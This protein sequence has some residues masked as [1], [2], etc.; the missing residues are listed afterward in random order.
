MSSDMR[1]FC[2]GVPLTRADE[3]IVSCDI[4]RLSVWS[5]IRPRLKRSSMIPCQ[6]SKIKINRP[7]LLH[8]CPKHSNRLVVVLVLVLGNGQ[9]LLE[10]RRSVGDYLQILLEEGLFLGCL[11]EGLE[12]IIPFPGYF[13]KRNSELCDNRGQHMRVEG[14]VF[15]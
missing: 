5:L 4:R 1:L 6:G 3:S 12:D 15:E 2:D 10:F 7:A 9:L 11:L 8:L 14:L 13:G